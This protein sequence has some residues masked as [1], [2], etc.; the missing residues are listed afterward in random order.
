L[1]F[2]GMQYTVN[3]P[4]PAGV[5]ERIRISLKSA[6]LSNGYVWTPSR[7]QVCRVLRVDPKK[8]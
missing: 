7:R 6:T 3:Y 5:A 2:P 8:R 4:Y 1:F